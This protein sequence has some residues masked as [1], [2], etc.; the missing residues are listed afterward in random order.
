MFLKSGQFASSLKTF[1]YKTEECIQPIFSLLHVF[2]IIHYTFS[3][4]LF[5]EESAIEAEDERARNE[6]R[7]GDIVR[8]ENLLY[9]ILGFHWS[10]PDNL[11]LNSVK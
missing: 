4:T 10:R 9:L 11:L 6:L 1:L 2:F 8:G 3:E 5:Y 7:I